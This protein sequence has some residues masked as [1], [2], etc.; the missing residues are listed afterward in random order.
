MNVYYDSNST[1][2]RDNFSVPLS[3]EVLV[4]LVEERNL[5]VISIGEMLKTEND[6][7]KKQKRLE[8][9]KYSIGLQT[10][11]HNRIFSIK[12]IPAQ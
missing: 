2:I 3:V 4:Y 11:S 6:K 8:K 12:P 7:I 9:I 5:N 1:L 10:R